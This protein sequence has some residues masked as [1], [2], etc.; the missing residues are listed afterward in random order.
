MT[1]YEPTD[2]D[3]EFLNQIDQGYVGL[4]KPKIAHGTDIG[5]SYLERRAEEP[6]QDY[7]RLDDQG[8]E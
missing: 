6:E 7:M 8:M 2:E 5:M 1:N 3:I 4:Q